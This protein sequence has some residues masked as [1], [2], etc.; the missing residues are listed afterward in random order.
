MPYRFGHWHERASTTLVRG[1]GMCT[2][3]ANLQV[4]LMR[5]A[6]L[7]AGFV[8]TPMPMSKL[9]KLMPDAWL[10][11][12]RNEVRHYFAAV[13]LNGTWWACDA[14]YDDTAFKIYIETMPELS[15][16]IPAFFDEGR[17]YSPAYEAKGDDPTDIAVVAHLEGVM[18]KSSRFGP[19]HFEALNT[20]VDRARGRLRRREWA[21]DGA[22]RDKARGEASA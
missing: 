9:G 3:K 17:P 16:L 15:F 6:G 21:G 14:S 18:G 22:M 5:A 12:M 1:V 19:R 2:T 20:K 13:K 7:E 4:A 10:A 11:L 8:E